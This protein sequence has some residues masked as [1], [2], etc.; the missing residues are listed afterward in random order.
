M[1]S[2]ASWQAKQTI[3]LPSFIPSGRRDQD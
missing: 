3:L 2:A 1:G